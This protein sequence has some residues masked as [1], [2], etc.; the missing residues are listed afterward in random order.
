MNKKK[1]WIEIDLSSESFEPRTV[2]SR[3]SSKDVHTDR[4]SR[5]L[6]RMQRP[7]PARER[8][9]ALRRSAVSGLR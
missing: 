6:E 2:E 3:F 7:L 8:E 5:M 1:D 9:H 4:G